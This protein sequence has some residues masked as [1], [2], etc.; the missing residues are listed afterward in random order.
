MIII[1]PLR[2]TGSGNPGYKIQNSVN[3]NYSNGTTLKNVS[4]ID[5][6]IT[7]MAFTMDM[8]SGYDANG[9]RITNII[10]FD[11]SELL[12]YCPSCE[13]I[14]P[15]TDFGWSGRVTTS[16]RDQSECNHCRSSY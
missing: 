3:I 8:S 4:I 12:K 5:S 10:G 16:R 6:S 9:N 1:L 7:T 14:K 11:G 2:L 13:Y 15:S